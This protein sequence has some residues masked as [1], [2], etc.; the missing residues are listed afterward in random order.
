[1]IFFFFFEFICEKNKKINVFCVVISRNT[2]SSQFTETTEQLWRREDR[3]KKKAEEGGKENDGGTKHLFEWK[4]A[5]PD[6]MH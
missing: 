6:K 4:H 5:G 2:K 3:K 1:M